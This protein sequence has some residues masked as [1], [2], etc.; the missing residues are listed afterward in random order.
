MSGTEIKTPIRK[1]NA[2]LKQTG[3]RPTSN[4]F[5]AANDSGERV[6][7][8]KPSDDLPYER[9]SLCPGAQPAA[10]A[11]LVRA[12]G[13]ALA[14]VASMTV[15]QG[16]VSVQQVEYLLKVATKESSV[17]E[18]LIIAFTCAL[19]HEIAGSEGIEAQDGQNGH[20]LCSSLPA[21]FGLPN[22]L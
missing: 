9:A 20:T 7:P 2:M 11:E 4:H 12:I 14:L 19:L 3:E 13:G 16:E 21:M 1:A 17:H 10:E 15:R 5:Q 6:S 22:L 8:T 18:G